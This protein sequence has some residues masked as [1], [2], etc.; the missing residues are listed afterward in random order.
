MTVFFSTNKY[1][2][3]LRTY[4]LDDLPIGK[5]FAHKLDGP[6]LCRQMQALGIDG[7]TPT[8]SHQEMSLILGAFLAEQ[9]EKGE[10]AA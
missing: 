7:I 10:A 1:G 6:S 5:T 2:G 4:N 8:M 3:R 9:K